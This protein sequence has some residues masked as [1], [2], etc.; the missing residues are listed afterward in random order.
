[1]IK[2]KET[3]TKDGKTYVKRRYTFFN[4][5]KYT[6]ECCIEYPKDRAKLLPWQKDEPA[7]TK[8]RLIDNKKD[9]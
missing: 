1:M 3:F 4:I 6:V 5:G 8:P 2:S 9:K 7:P